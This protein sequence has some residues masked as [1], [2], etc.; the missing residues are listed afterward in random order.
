MLEINV[1]IENHFLT[2]AVANGL[3]IATPMGSL[4]YLCSAGCLFKPGGFNKT[5]L[6]FINLLSPAGLME[7][8]NQA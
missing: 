2:Q 7:R 8:D 1:S 5:G 4:A 6:N 3:I